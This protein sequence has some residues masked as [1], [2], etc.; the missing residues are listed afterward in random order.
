LAEDKPLALNDSPGHAT[1]TY[2]VDTHAIFL[3][4]QIVTAIAPDFLQFPGIQ[5][6]FK[7]GFLA[8][9]PQ[10]LEKFMEPATSA[11]GNNVID[12]YRVHDRNL[13]Q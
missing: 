7:H 3:Q 11:I 1:G 12:H 13:F 2:P 10:F 8:A 9:Y 4:V 5:T 6:A